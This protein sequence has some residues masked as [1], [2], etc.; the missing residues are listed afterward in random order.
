M[1]ILCKCMSTYQNRF[2]DSLAYQVK[3]ESVGRCLKLRSAGSVGVVGDSL[4]LSETPVEDSLEQVPLVGL[5][6]DFNFFRFLCVAGNILVP[7]KDWRL[8][9]FSCFYSPSYGRQVQTKQ[10][11]QHCAY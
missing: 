9:V 5:S 4:L 6:P 3:F 1:H 8:G 10:M 11:S 7:E 2:K